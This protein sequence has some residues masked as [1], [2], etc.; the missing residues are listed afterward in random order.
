[1][2][3][4]GLFVYVAFLISFSTVFS[5]EGTNLRLSK[6]RL[7]NESTMSTSLSTLNKS[8]RNMCEGNKPFAKYCLTNTICCENRFDICV[9]KVTSCSVWNIFRTKCEVGVFEDVCG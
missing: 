5:K 6:M 4:V 9:R 1:M 8:E 3:I 2:K 7:T